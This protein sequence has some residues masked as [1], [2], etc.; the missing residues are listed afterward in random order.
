MERSKI[1][2]DME[3]DDKTNLVK[4]MVQAKEIAKMKIFDNF[5]TQDALKNYVFDDYLNG[6]GVETV[7]PNEKKAHFYMF[8][9]G[10]FK[11]YDPLLK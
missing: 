4:S 7:Y 3:E 9:D 2:E 6:Q 8:D 10:N 5:Y 1:D 11:V